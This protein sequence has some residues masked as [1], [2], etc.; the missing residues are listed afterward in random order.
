[1][2]HRRALALT[3]LVGVV[4]FLPPDASAQTWALGDTLTVIQKP[5]QN[6]PEI[7]V[8]G[9]QL[10]IRC[11][12]DPGTTGWQVFL[13]RGEFNIPLVL[14]SAT[15]DSP[16]TWWRLAAEVPQVPLLE[17]YDLKVTASGGLVDVARQSVQV[18][19]TFP[20]EFYFVHITDT[21]LPTYLYYDENGAET[22]SST[23]IGLRHITQD[24]NLINPVFVLVTG[25]L[26]NE[27]ELE[28][29]LSRRYYSRAQRQLREFEVPVFLTAGNHD[30]GGWDPTPPPAGT[31]RRDWWRFFGWKRL[32]DPPAGA[33]ARTQDYSF[34]F[35][36]VHFV[37]LEAYDNYDSWRWPI[38][39]DESFT[40][41]QLNWLQ[42]DL[43][44]TDR[45]TKVLFHHHDFAGEL[46]LELLGVDLALSGHIH[47]DTEDSSVPLAITTDNASGTNR[48]FRLIRYAD[49]Q[50]FTQPSLEAGFDGQTLTTTYQP[51]DSGN[52]DLVRVTIQNGY[53]QAFDDGRLKLAMPEGATRFIVEGGTLIQV[54]QT[55]AHPV[56]HLKVSI[57]A[58]GS[59][60]VTL[61]V[62]DAAPA[63]ETPTVVTR[64]LGAHPNPFN[65]RTVLSFELAAEGAVRLDIFDLQGRLVRTLVDAHLERGTHTRVW[66]G[67]DGRG[68]A[69][70]SGTYLAALRLLDYSETR[71]ITLVR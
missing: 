55:G 14:L 31:A 47:R 16:T 63:E 12:A 66:D 10:D 65:P 39:G 26:I 2:F 54:D 70:P 21:H 5:L 6:I 67:F 60:T 38:Y 46:N 22:D 19:A 11:E 32:D 1:M 48:P 44:A 8:S 3:I 28:D 18:R 20:D 37:G 49:G 42:Q 45:S 68:G 58:S 33:P 43:Q 56:C 61:K 40:Q 34:D 7:V 9:G 25:D 4:L 30:I 50:F 23:T 17:I 59:L 41:D 64:L 51:D 69:L 27:G 36:P 62:D 15:Y 53:A 71:K 35:G 52:H 13:E 24:V 29:F 57:P